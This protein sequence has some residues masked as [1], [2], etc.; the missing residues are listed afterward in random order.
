MNRNKPILSEFE[1][2]RVRNFA[3]MKKLKLD[4]K[5][6]YGIKSLVHE[7]DFADQNVYA[8]YAPNGSM[9]SSLA[10]TFRDV[11][12]GIPSKDR[13][14]LNRPTSR[15]I[16]DETG[17]PIPD[18]EVFVISPYEEEFSAG[19]KT[20]TLLVNATL[21]KEY[22]ALHAEIERIKGSLLDAL[23]KQSGSKRD[24]EEEISTAILKEN[25]LRNALT[26]VK[27][28]VGRLKDTSLSNKN[29]G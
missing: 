9:K 23:K 15:S 14:F 19:G 12:N 5:N 10:Q 22:D 18:S 29:F 20:S 7:F 21:K 16:T 24:I 27:D 28:E 4:L 13:I 25:N 6:C 11:S 2:G 3:F 1:G 26:R 17:T 8:I